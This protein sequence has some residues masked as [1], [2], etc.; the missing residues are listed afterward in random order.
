MSNVR[1]KIEENK[2]LCYDLTQLNPEMA[3]SKKGAII[4]VDLKNKG[5]HKM[6][7]PNYCRL[8]HC[9]GGTM[10]VLV[11]DVKKTICSEKHC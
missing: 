10:Q 6:K 7:L 3:F 2:N 1:N 9:E 8:I 4:Y 5:I 11:D